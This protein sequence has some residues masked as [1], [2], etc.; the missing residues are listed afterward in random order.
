MS[1]IAER[2]PEL[3]AAQRRPWR[4]AFAA[5]AVA[6]TISTHWPAL[7]LGP[8]VPTSDKTIHLI[9]FGG[10]TYLLW[11]TGWFRRLTTLTIVALAWSALDEWS[12]SLPIVN[13]TVTPR[14]LLANALGVLI[15]VVWLWA[16]RPVGGPVSRRRTHLL[17]F[18]F[19]EA[20]RRPRIWRQLVSAGLLVVIPIAVLWFV[21]EAGHTRRLILFGALAWVLIAKYL[22]F[23]HGRA[24]LIRIAR[25]RPCFRCGS[26]AGADDLPRCP[27]CDS[28]LAAGQW[29]MPQLP[30]ASVILRTLGWP[31]IGVILVLT[32]GMTAIYVGIVTH[33]F[34]PG[35]GPLADVMRVIGGLPRDVS[36]ALDLTLC[37]V[38]IAVATAVY[39]RRL[40]RHID[41]GA[42]CR[43]CG[44]DLRGTPATDGA[45]QCGECG[46]SFV[47]A[48]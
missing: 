22:T 21:L 13:R 12:Q 2:T 20:F 48:A 46:A 16:L 23:F 44:H 3:L 27:S 5:Y 42:V 45:G 37:L 6:L 43:V 41:A 26:P 29:T 11:R 31:V 30:R 9:A 4:L 17:H 10:L 25:E 33:A 18:A 19:D 32:A 7:E 38:L 36:S 15:V 40:A 39:R 35:S 47:R 8:Q 14:D 34:L 1:D 28:A 24:A